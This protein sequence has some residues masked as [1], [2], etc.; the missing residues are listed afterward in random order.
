MRIHLGLVVFGIICHIALA[1]AQETESTS[2]PT[3]SVVSLKAT[4]EPA[5]DTSTAPTI[6]EGPANSFYGLFLN[7][8]MRDAEMQNTESADFD[9]E[10]CT[11]HVQPKPWRK[12]RLKGKKKRSP[13]RTNSLQ[14]PA[15]LVKD[16]GQDARAECSARSSGFS[17]RERKT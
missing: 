3:N 7:S 12:F 6:Q 11:L 10:K 17:E 9:W 8:A 16:Q 15:K 5:R 13:P 4:D 1:C 2:S 14:I